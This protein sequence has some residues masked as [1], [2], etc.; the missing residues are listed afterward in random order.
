MLFIN[1][2]K[3]I[4]PQWVPIVRQ[5]LSTM[6]VDYLQ[7]LI[8]DNDWLP[9]LEHVVA[10]FSMSLDDTHYILLGE[11]PYP[12][13][14]SA[15]GYAFWDASVKNLW[16]NKGL[17][18]EVNRATSLRNF[19]KMLLV[20]RG[21]LSLD[22]SQMAIASLDKKYYWQTAEQLFK[23][24]IASGFLLLNAT[25]VFAPDKV[26]FHAKYWQPFMKSLLLQLAEC[27]PMIKILLFG[28]IAA[29]VPEVDHF[30]CLVA[31]HPYNLSFIRNPDVLAFFSP[32]DILSSYER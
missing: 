21:D 16:S 22:V 26:K 25:L 31:E 19:I 4:H 7:Q 8:H 17:S 9:G 18:K 27:K 20:A 5:A 10:A 14:I 13:G 2:L 3:K 28:K 15:N 32:L 12:R 30:K 29:Q 23:N 11:S 24:M 6:D 1:F